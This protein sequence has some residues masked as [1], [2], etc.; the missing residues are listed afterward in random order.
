MPQHTSTTPLNLFFNPTH[1][2]GRTRFNHRAV[3]ALIPARQA[4]L[5]SYLERCRRIHEGASVEV[6]Q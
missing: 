3:E 2:I 6:Q 5:R 1:A 4:R